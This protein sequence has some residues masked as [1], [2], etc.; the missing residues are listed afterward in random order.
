MGKVV[1]IYFLPGTCQAL[2]IANYNESHEIHAVS[3]DITGTKNNNF[4]CRTPTQ[5]PNVFLYLWLQDIEAFTPFSLSLLHISQTSLVLS[6]RFA[7]STSFISL[8]ISFHA[9]HYISSL[10]LSATSSFFF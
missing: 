4:L 3:C 5:M 1:F 10:Q 2:P 9:I 7:L 8:M 6:P